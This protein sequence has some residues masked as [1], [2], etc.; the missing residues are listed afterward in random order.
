MINSIFCYSW[1]ITISDK[2]CAFFRFEYLFD[3]IL[4]ISNDLLHCMATIQLKKCLIFF[5]FFQL[6]L[7]VLHD[8]IPSS[9][10][11]VEMIFAVVPLHLSV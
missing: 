8:Y 5:Y 7:M 6:M 1:H 4:F 3:N 9:W 2:P 11:T 10:H